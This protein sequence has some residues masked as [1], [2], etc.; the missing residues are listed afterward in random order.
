M[1]EINSPENRMPEPVVPLFAGSRKL[2]WNAPLRW[3]ALGWQDIWRAPAISLSYGAVFVAFS[4]R[5][6]P[7]RSRYAAAAHPAP[8]TAPTARCPGRAYRR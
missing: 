3:L 6:T 4:Y 1:A 5:R 8:G 7:A 2:A